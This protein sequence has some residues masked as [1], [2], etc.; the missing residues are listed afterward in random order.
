MFYASI[1]KCTKTTSRKILTCGKRSHA[2]CVVF[3]DCRFEHPKAQNHT[4]TCNY[5]NSSIWNTHKCIGALNEG[6]IHQHG[7]CGVKW[8]HTP[9]CGISKPVIEN[10]EAIGFSVGNIPNYSDT[11]A[12]VS[13]H[14]LQSTY[15]TMTVC[16]ECILKASTVEVEVT[17]IYLE[18]NLV[19]TQSVRHQ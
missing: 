8:R 11:V 6:G 19:H 12:I 13:L 14:F 16:W 10:S 4:I 9:E 5:I 15:S 1:L 2:L 17:R 18:R 7:G 3:A